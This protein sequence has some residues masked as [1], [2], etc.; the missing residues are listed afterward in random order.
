MNAPA[1]YPIRTLDERRAICRVPVT[2]D[3]E[4]ALVCGAACDFP[5][6][7]TMDGARR[8]EYGW[9]VYSIPPVEGAV[10]TR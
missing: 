5:I 2:L 3:G 9:K 1:Q 8:V 4:P 6:V 10:T 7:S